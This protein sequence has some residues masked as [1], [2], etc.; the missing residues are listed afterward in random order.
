ME[1]IVGVG[2]LLLDV[3]GDETRVFAVR[4][5]EAKP[6]YFKERGMISFPLET[7]DPSI[8]STEFETIQRLVKEEIGVPLAE[9]AFSG[10]FEER[11]SLIPG[12]K[13]V[14]TVYGYGFFQG[15]PGR[16]FKPLDTDIQFAGWYTFLEL[17]AFPKIRVE[18]TPIV[19]D[20]IK[21]KCF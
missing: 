12:R 5:L 3:R 21:R 4:E 18:T 11:F 17:L 7:F 10:L 14:E 20:F 13:D 8:D 16:K 19:W 15:D 1:K 6:Q 2:F 9:V